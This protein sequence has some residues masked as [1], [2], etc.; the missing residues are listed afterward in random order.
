MRWEPSGQGWR[1]KWQRLPCTNGS[2]FAITW[3]ATDG[4]YHNTAPRRWPPESR[5]WLPPKPLRWVLIDGEGKERKIQLNRVNSCSECDMVNNNNRRRLNG[6]L[7]PWPSTETGERARTHSMPNFVSNAP[8]SRK[9][10]WPNIWIRSLVIVSANNFTER[11]WRKVRGKTIASG[12]IY[13]Y[14][15]MEWG[16]LSSPHVY[17]ISYLP[18]DSPVV[19]TSYNRRNVDM[20]Y[21][22]PD[23]AFSVCHCHFLP[24]VS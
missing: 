15:A 20:S 10:S 22:N 13:T 11:R 6:G 24:R 1:S 7:I 18:S 17:L 23:G 8:Q 14:I 4:K 2:V 5:R 21:I 16:L 12:Q 3:T 19:H 9:F